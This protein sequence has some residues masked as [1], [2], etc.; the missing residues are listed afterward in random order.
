MKYVPPFGS[1]APDAP[2]VDRDTPGA[3]SGSRVPAAAVEHGQRE[4]VT[5]IRKSGLTPSE[6]DLTQ[7][8]RAVRARRLNYFAAGGTANAIAITMD[9]EP[10]SWAELDGAPLLVVLGAANTS[11][12]VTLA[13]TGLTTRA[14]V[15]ND[16][17]LPRPGDL[18]GPMEFTY[19]AA[20][21]K[22]VI[23]S[24]SRTATINV[25]RLTANTTFYVRPDGDDSND[26]F[27]NTVAGAFR[28]LSGAYSRVSQEY[29][30]TGYVV[31]FALGIPG[32]YVG[33][34]FPSQGGTWEIAGPSWEAAGTY[35][36]ES[37]PGLAYGIYSSLSD[38]RIRRCAIRTVYTG[39]ETIETGVQAANGGNILLDDI[40]TIQNNN[41]NTYRDIYVNTRGNI[42]CIN[43]I[44]FGGAGQ[45]FGAVEC[46]NQGIFIAADNPASPT[47]FYTSGTMSM[48]G[49]WCRASLGGLANWTNSNL[50][51]AAAVGTR[52]YADT[53]GGIDTSGAVASYLPGNAGGATDGAT[54]G[55][56]R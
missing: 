5:L 17:S 11:T 51:G 12:A 44:Q 25:R 33:A 3:I 56:Y 27:T 46:I 45:R 37:A 21:D 16:G 32:T 28:T 1:A 38:L 50:S 2:Y 24:A 6:Q 48:A 20:L 9:L 22:V 54:M 8:S 47:Q 30:S 39:S 34:A 15:Y 42:R 13:P 40:V 4:L 7:V 52:Y 18:V 49:V 14:I 53:G 29:D 26:G 43:R 36:I 31:T 35:I 41:R 55:W 19:V 10:A 23:T